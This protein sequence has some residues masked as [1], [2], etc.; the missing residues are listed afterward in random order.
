MVNGVCFLCI[1]RNSFLLARGYQ[2]D[3]IRGI[4]GGGASVYCLSELQCPA[5]GECFLVLKSEI[6]NNCCIL[7]A[8]HHRFSYHVS[9]QILI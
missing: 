4:R 8:I 9:C 7:G 3:P 1:G 2:R 5:N 6:C